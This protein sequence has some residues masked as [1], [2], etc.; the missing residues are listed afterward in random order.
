[1]AAAMLGCSPGPERPAQAPSAGSA[2]EPIEIRTDRSAYRAGD[3]VELTVLNRG[4]DTLGFNPCTR[5]ME[6]EKNGGWETLEEPDR[7]CTMEAWILGPGETRTSRTELP[8]D[9]PSGRYRVALAFTV[10]G[11]AGGGARLTARSAPVT[12]Q[13]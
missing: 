9:M 11:D 2:G 3:P 6:R 4:R 8:P 12:V 13:R 1:M 7:I 5:T 10:E